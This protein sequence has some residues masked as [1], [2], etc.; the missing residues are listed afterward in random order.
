MNAPATN[1]RTMPLFSHMVESRPVRGSARFADDSLEQEALLDEIVQWETG[2]RKFD[3]ED[4]RAYARRAE[5]VTA[6]LWA[7]LLAKTSRSA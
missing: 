3:G 2:S 7:I 1:S 4:P 5:R 6:G